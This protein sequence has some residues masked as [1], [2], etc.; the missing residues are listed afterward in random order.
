MR[1]TPQMSHLLH[2]LLTVLATPLNVHVDVICVISID[3]LGN[4]GAALPKQRD[5]CVCRGFA[6]TVL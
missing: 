3:A 4:H 6:M 2:L 5:L 1:E